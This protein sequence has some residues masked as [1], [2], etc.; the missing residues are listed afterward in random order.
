MS[1]IAHNP[2]PD[3]PLYEVVATHLTLLA[4]ASSVALEGLRVA[5]G[6]KKEPITDADRK[7]AER[8]RQEIGKDTIPPRGTETSQPEGETSGRRTRNPDD[9]SK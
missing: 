5:M 8:V 1:E 3:M 2:Y 7:K 9:D 6:R 4:E